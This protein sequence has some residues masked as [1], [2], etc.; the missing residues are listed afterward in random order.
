MKHEFLSDEISLSG[1]NEMSLERVF[2]ELA[3]QTEYVTVNA[4]DLTLFHIF[5]EEDGNKIVMLDKTALLKLEIRKSLEVGKLKKELFSETIIN[6]NT[7][8]NINDRS[9]VGFFLTYDGRILEVSVEAMYML[10]NEL[11]IQLKSNRRKTFVRNSYIALQ[12]LHCNKEFV[13]ICRKNVET[14]KTRIFAVFKKGHVYIPQKNILQTIKRINSSDVLTSKHGL[15]KI[16]KWSLNQQ[17]TRIWCEFENSDSSIFS[18]G[19]LIEVSDTR[20]EGWKVFEI[21]RK[22][23]EKSYLIG[24]QFDFK[25]HIDDLSRILIQN[26]AEKGTQ[27]EKYLDEK[28]NHIL[29]S[30]LDLTSTQNWKIHQ[31]RMKKLLL[32]ILEKSNLASLLGKKRTAMVVTYI[33]ESM[34]FSRY[35]TEAD[36]ILIFMSIPETLEALG[37]KLPSVL[38]NAVAKI[39]F[40]LPFQNLDFSKLM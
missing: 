4:K 7:I 6:E 31:R 22:K 28:K 12:L 15:L 8:G 9:A 29:F 24:D 30:D 25:N 10:I 34:D 32:E 3:S 5:S 20:Q 37:G 38:I 26:Y 19:I 14:G 17:Q 1:D 40:K 39:A 18:H 2:S 33:L 13:L 16:K 23:G 11:G 36:L 35:L 21:L 27:V